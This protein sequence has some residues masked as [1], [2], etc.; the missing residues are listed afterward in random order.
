MAI[1]PVSLFTPS[2][3][4]AVTLPGARRQNSVDA[5]PAAVANDILL[6]PAL[7]DVS[8]PAARAA[9]TSATTATNAAQ[10]ATPTTLQTPPTNAAAAA[11]APVVTDTAPPSA[12]RAIAAAPAAV[13]QAPP[14]ATDSSTAALQNDIRRQQTELLQLAASP[15]SA[16]AT[17]TVPDENV[18][19]QRLL[20]LRQDDASSLAVAIR[21]A[22]AEQ[23]LLQ[24]DNAQSPAQSLQPVLVS[25]SNSALTTPASAPSTPAAAIASEPV[26]TPLAAALP[27]AVPATSAAAPALP[28]SATPEGDTPI[29]AAATPVTP[30]PMD[31]V[32]PALS[33]PALGNL[34]PFMLYPAP[35]APTA[36]LAEP[37]TPL[38]PPDGPIVTA[39]AATADSLQGNLSPRL[40]YPTPASGQAIR[41]TVVFSAEPLF[42]MRG[43]LVD[44]RV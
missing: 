26:V 24:Q 33:R 19:A 35:V 3:P 34:E 25:A 30:Q 12:T 1:T 36:N 20:Q 11:P 32:A 2:L 15:D 17:E 41:A 7:T 22:A 27:A 10:L 39:A 37:V 4:P 6:D 23:A 8:P 14:V 28:P 31:R 44:E 13:E 43:T 42:A 16:T 9:L 21:A 18:L 5:N 40:P 29:T 38:A